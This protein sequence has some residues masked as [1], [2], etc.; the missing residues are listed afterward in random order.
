MSLA[1]HVIENEAKRS[2]GRMGGR[3]RY[4]ARFVTPRAGTRRGSIA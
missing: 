2:V 1:T 3:L 4:R